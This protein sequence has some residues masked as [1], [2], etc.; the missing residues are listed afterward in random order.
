MTQLR[1][2][3]L[4]ALI[5]ISLDLA[6]AT[7]GTAS[8]PNVLLMVTDDQRPDTIRALGNPYIETPNIDRLVEEGSAF[9]RAIVAIPHCMPSRAEIM[10]GASGFRNQSPPFREAIDPTCVL[11]ANVMRG[12]GYHTWYSGKWMNDGTPL[13]RG[14]DET[15]AM[16][17]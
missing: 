4:A 3:P 10:T 2:P 16:W 11:W 15:R 7:V 12:A 9:T 5:A 13:T 6:A 17:A 8:R 1:L 14:Y